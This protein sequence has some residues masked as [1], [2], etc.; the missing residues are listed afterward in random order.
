M[1]KINQKNSS[2]H[3][4]LKLMAAMSRQGLTDSFFWLAGDMLTM[5]ENIPMMPLKHSPGK[6]WD[7][8]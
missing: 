3:K 7:T 4:L 2:L 8:G 5:G 1:K 6:I